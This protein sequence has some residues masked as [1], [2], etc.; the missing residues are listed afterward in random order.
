MAGKKGAARPIPGHLSGR[1]LRALIAARL[2]HI[3]IHRF[4][5]KEMAKEL[6]AV[7]DL[8]DELLAISLIQKAKRPAPS[9]AQ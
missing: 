2:R 9:D 5:K 4:S 7:Q 8:R 6:Q 1:M 3:R